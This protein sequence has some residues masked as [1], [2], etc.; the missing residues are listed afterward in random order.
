[1]YTIL[2]YITLVYIYIYIYIYIYTHP[3]QPPLGGCPRLTCKAA[4]RRTSTLHRQTHGSTNDSLLNLLSQRDTN[5]GHLSSNSRHCSQWHRVLITKLLTWRSLPD[6]LGHTPKTC[7]SGLDAACAV[8]Q[9]YVQPRR[10]RQAT[11]RQRPARTAGHG[12]LTSAS[13]GVS[14]ALSQH[15]G[16]PTGERERESGR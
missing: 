7:G 14:P 1:M 15:C 10:G 16:S 11:R 12:G 6:R 13:G 2:Y 4:P 3:R 9:A 5:R 8:E